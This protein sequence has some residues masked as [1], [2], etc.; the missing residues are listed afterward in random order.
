MVLIH[1]PADT[2]KV[3]ESIA[4]AHGNVRAYLIF[5]RRGNVFFLLSHRQA[6]DSSSGKVSLSRSRPFLRSSRLQVSFILS[7][8]ILSLEPSLHHSLLPRP[9][10][11]PTHKRLRPYISHTFTNAWPPLAD[12]LQ[13]Y[14]TSPGSPINSHIFP[15]GTRVYRRYG[16]GVA[17]K[18]IL[19]YLDLFSKNSHGLQRFAFPRRSTEHPPHR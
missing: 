16:L 4:R 5:Q 13:V 19:D 14:S 10:S 7:I 6:L 12:Q 8:I 1:V 3:D 9:F 17:Y 15:P 11:P 2:R 18:F